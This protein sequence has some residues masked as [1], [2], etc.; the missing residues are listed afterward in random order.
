[1][2]KKPLQVRLVGRSGKEYHIEFPK[3]Q[4]PVTVN[5]NLYKRMLQSPEYRFMGHRV[6]SKG[7]AMSPGER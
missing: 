3:V 1:M 2:K 5:E 6:G 4:V 7:Q